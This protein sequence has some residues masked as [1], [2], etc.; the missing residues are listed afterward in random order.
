MSNT[1]ISQNVHSCWLLIFFSNQY[2]QNTSPIIL[3]EPLKYGICLGKLNGKTIV[4]Q[5]VPKSLWHS[6]KWRDRYNIKT[7]MPS[8]PSTFNAMISQ[9]LQI[10]CCNERSIQSGKKTV[11]MVEPFKKYRNNR[12]NQIERWAHCSGVYLDRSDWWP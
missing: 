5:W 8:L 11:E 7:G 9:K 6:R 12:L 10:I 4:F 2:S 1:S 3:S